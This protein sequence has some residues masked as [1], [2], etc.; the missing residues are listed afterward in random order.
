MGFVFLR[1]Q[2]TEATSFLDDLHSYYKK[3]VK[4]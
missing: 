2:L 4:I 1:N 3:F